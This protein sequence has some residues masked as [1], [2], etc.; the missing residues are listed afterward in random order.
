MFLTSPPTMDASAVGCGLMLLFKLV[1]LCVTVA[2]FL[3]LSLYV[4]VDGSVG[5]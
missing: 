5:L 4:A 1:M 2:S 3:P